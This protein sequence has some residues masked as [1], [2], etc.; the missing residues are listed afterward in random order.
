MELE[1]FGE[2]KSVHAWSQDDRCAVSFQA[3]RRRVKLNW[4][5]ERAITEPR[6]QRTSRPLKVITAFNATMTVGEWA[7]DPRCIVTEARLRY[8]LHSGWSP[9]RAMTE[10]LRGYVAKPEC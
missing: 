2:T 1:A 6:T 3:L 7:R 10:P 4:P 8:R 5:A 9:E